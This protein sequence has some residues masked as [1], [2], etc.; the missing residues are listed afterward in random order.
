MFYYNIS[1]S[2]LRVW[3]TKIIPKLIS[4]EIQKERSINSDKKARI[5]NTVWVYKFNF[6]CRFMIEN[7]Q[8]SSVLSRI[9]ITHF[10]PKLFF[11]SGHY[12]FS[13]LFCSC[14]VIICLQTGL[15][16]ASKIA[17]EINEFIFN[18]NSVRNFF[19]FLF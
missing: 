16:R 8:Q 18:A 3:Q 1:K 13:S 17:I 14:V 4:Q 15:I 5:E 9:L 10:S 12:H 19:Q 7:K 2:L 11:S 6:T